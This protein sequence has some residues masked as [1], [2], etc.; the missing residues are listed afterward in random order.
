MTSYKTTP[1]PVAIP[2]G[3]LARLSRFGALAS[4]IAGRA[5]LG[6]LQ[7][8]VSG[9]APRGRDLLLTPGNAARLANQLAEMRG[10]AMK[11]GQLLSMEAGD[12][13]PSE[14][15]DILGR[16][17]AQADFMPPR[18]LKSVLIDNWGPDFLQRFDRFDVTPIAAAS[19]GQVHRARLRDGRE[20]AIKVQYP[21]VRRSIDSDVANVATLA[22]MAGLLPKTIDV[23]PLLDEAKRQLHEEADY[24]REARC[25]EQFGALLAGSPDFRAPALYAP[26]STRDILAMDF[27]EGAPIESLATAPQATRDRVARLLVELFLRELFEFGLMQTDANFANFRYDAASGQVILLDFGAT[28]AFEPSV[29]DVYRRFL[30]VGLGGD[31]AALR[32]ATIAMGFF[33]AATAERHQAAVLDMIEIVFAPIREGG[34]FDFGATD[35][36]ER[37]RRAGMALGADRE[38]EHIPPIDALFAQRKAAGLFL[39]ASRLR[40][41]VDVGRLLAPYL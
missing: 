36:V 25:L 8:G 2:S 7:S 29:T 1:K 14:F 39:L 40:A 19:I 5:A 4:G 35:L 18:Q 17:R 9:R 31:R 37:L 16:L 15:S 13:L 28:R 34:L 26:L 27:V 21:G 3:R 38:F 6:A 12:L 32:D 10:A 41:R 11:V 20:L 30:A 22:R 24:E 23:A 33:D